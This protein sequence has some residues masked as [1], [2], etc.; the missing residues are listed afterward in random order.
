MLGGQP[1]IA[2]VAMSETESARTFYRDVLGLKL[3]SDEPTA[4]IFAA[5]D[6]R[7]RVAL[8]DRVVP[9]PYTVL[10]WSVSD[11]VEVAERLAAQGVVLERFPRLV[12]DER[13]IWTSPGGAQLIWFR[14]PAGNLLS[15]TQFPD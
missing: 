11:V 5:G 1:L 8:V 13:G 3:L 6:T 9:A 15:V 2:F 7:L 12:Q 14:D 4:L 10:G